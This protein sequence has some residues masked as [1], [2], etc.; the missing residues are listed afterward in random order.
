MQCKGAR[1]DYM[2]ELPGTKG[3]MINLHHW[4]QG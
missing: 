4:I 1:K 2:L 3:F